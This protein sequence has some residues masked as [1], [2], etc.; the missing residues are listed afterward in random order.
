MARVLRPP[1]RSHALTSRA[2]DGCKS[3]CALIGPSCQKR[4]RQPRALRALQ[5]LAPSPLAQLL[6][7]FRTPSRPPF[8][9]GFLPP[10]QVFA[11]SREASLKLLS[12]TSQTVRCAPPAKAHPYPGCFLEGR[13][14][15]GK[16]L[17]ALWALRPPRLLFR[18]YRYSWKSCVNLEAGECRSAVNVADLGRPAAH[19]RSL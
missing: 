7:P 6:L 1:R 12:G 15:Q 14:G 16:L 11:A 19:S 5:R 13:G 18:P 8:V 3:S 10:R 17:Y 4:W 2:V 9:P